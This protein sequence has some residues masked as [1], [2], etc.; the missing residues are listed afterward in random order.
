M[1]NLLV[2]FCLAA[3]MFAA[4]PE[5]EVK[6]AEMAWVEGI[7]KNDFPKL[8]K[9]L[10]EDLYYLHSTGS[11]DTKAS[12]IDSMKT[13]RQKYASAKI[14]ELKVRVYGKA[15]VINGDADFEFITA[16]K[17]GKG[18]LKYTHVFAKGPKGWQ[19]V[20]HQSLRVPE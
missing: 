4:S 14:R 13:G 20:S 2:L 3:P 15:A 11:A 9:V 18:R 1:R 8:E 6:A 17:P 5:E 12:Y 7:T 19:L 10:A 16:G